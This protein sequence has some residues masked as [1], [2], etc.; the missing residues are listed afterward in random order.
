MAFAY[1]LVHTTFI[2]EY[3]K[4]LVVFFEKLQQDVCRLAGYTKR[5]H[6]RMRWWRQRRLE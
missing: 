6:W 2:E 4:S 1:S 5:A 3:V